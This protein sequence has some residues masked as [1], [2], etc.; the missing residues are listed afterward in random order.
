[1]V[2]F[3]LGLLGVALLAGS[4]DAGVLFR[5][6]A[7]YGGSGG[8]QGYQAGCV[9]RQASSGCYGGIRER[10]QERRDRRHGCQGYQASSGCLGGVPSA[11]VNKQAVPLPMPQKAAMN[12]EGDQCIVVH[13]PGIL[14]RALDA[15]GEVN[16]RRAARG[17]RPFVRDEGLTQAAQAAADYRAKYSIVGHTSNDFQFLPPGVN[18]ASA[19]CAAAD[20]TWGWLSCCSEENWTYAG[21]AY[22]VGSDGK[23]YMHLFVR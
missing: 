19:G 3:C 18:A 1:M 17:L 23:R 13:R 5:N 7:C 11:P 22:S 20:T 4:A 10:I 21:A 14:G 9:G 6:G 15:I 8:C 12:C 16:A 2:R